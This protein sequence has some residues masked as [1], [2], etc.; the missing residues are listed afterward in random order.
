VGAAALDP[1]RLLALY[2]AV[3]EGLTWLRP[4][5]VEVAAAFRPLR[6]DLEPIEAFERSLADALD[7]QTYD[8]LE[9]F[10]DGESDAVYGVG[11]GAGAGAGDRARVHLCESLELN[12]SPSTRS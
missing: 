5:L 1:E 12:A 8:R 7:E 3:P 10:F 2:D 4:H 6:E 11:A 9:A